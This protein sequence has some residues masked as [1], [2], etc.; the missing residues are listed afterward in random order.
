[1]D[2]SVKLYI[3]NIPNFFQLPHIMYQQR[4]TQIILYVALLDN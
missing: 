2:A 3:F 1:M 4:I